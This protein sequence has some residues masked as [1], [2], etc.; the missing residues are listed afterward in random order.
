MRFVSQTIGVA[1]EALDAA[2]VVQANIYVPRGTTIR[3]RNGGLRTLSRDHR[4]IELSVDARRQALTMASRGEIELRIETER[5]AIDYMTMKAMDRT[6]AK[7]SQGVAKQNLAAGRPITQ[8]WQM[9][10]IGI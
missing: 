6:I 1:S 9:G 4:L 8:S 5:M 3:I 7:L 2:N 10:K